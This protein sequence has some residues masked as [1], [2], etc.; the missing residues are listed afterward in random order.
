ML[1][2]SS[3]SYFKDKAEYKP[4]FSKNTG[5]WKIKKQI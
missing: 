1:S 2:E 4:P 5:G 3:P